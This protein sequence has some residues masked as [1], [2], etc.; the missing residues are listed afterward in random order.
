MLLKTY[1]IRFGKYKYWLLVTIPI[2]YFIL[3][4]LFDELGTF[5]DLRLEYGRQFNLIYN[6]FFSPYRQV[7]GVLFGLAFFMTAMKIKR[8]DL[9]GL[10]IMSG[11]GMTLIFGSTVIHGLSYL[12]AP[13]FGLVTISFMGLASYTL[14][15]GIFGSSRELA[16]DAVVR[17]ELNQIAGKQLSLFKNIGAAEMERTLV[18]NI[19]PIMDKAFFTKN[20]SLLD[21]TNQ[22]DYK[23]MVRE[24]LTELDSRKGIRKL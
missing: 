5:D 3:P 13:P 16:R 8:K 10:V 1:S 4:F 12:V 20:T 21:P 7:G 15:I 14:S 17:R 11:I 24:V 2:A 6:I 22:E 9:R 23:Q 19:K 18:R